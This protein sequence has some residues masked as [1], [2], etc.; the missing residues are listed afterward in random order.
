MKVGGKTEEE[1]RRFI[2]LGDRKRAE[3]YN[4]YTF[5]RWGDSASY[6]LCIDATKFGDDVERVVDLIKY[7]LKQ[8]NLIS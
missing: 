2:E 7:Y 8:R 6:D 5:K 3:Y 4:Y 1:A